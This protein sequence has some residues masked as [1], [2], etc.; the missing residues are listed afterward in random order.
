MR[1]RRA[2]LASLVGIPLSGCVTASQRRAEFASRE[3][4]LYI[5]TEQGD[6][7]GITRE[8]ERVVIWDGEKHGRAVHL[9]AVKQ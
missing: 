6:V 5:A 4:I 8:G 9:S 1:T 3:F 2:L 7:I